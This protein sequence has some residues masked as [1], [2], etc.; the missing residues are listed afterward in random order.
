MK[1]LIVELGNRCKQL[2]N[3]TIQT[4]HQVNLAASLYFE[5]IA[6]KVDQLYT[7]IFIYLASH[8]TTNMAFLRHSEPP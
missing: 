3:S 8:D 4:V 6:Q 2:T 5:T 1:R 7:L